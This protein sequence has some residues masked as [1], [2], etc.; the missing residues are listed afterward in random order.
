MRMYHIERSTYLL[1]SFIVIAETHNKASSSGIRLCDFLKTFDLTR[2]MTL[3]IEHFNLLHRVSGSHN[4]NNIAYIWLTHVRLHTT[5]MRFDGQSHVVGAKRWWIAPSSSS[6]KRSPKGRKYSP[7]LP[8]QSAS[9][10]AV[11]AC[12]LLTERLSTGDR[13]VRRSASLPTIVLCLLTDLLQH[14]C[15]HH[16]H[17]LAATVR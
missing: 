15:I 13:W 14:L 2:L 16:S 10:S 6:F 3:L 11:C 4:I 1:T 7:H 9:Y 8:I 5:Q 12:V 17:L